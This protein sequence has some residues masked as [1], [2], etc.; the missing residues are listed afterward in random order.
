MSGWERARSEAQK[1]T[2]VDEVLL[3][4]KRL[5]LS[6]PFDTIRLATIA[7]ELSFT[8]AN[9]YKYF[10]SKEEIYLT[11]LSQEIEQFSIDLDAA[12]DPLESSSPCDSN[13]APDAE[14]QP[15]EAPR[16]T[17]R[18]RKF[19]DVW[20]QLM[21]ERRA[22]LMLLACAGHILEKNVSDVTLL[23]SK[24][25]MLSAMT[26]WTVPALQRFFP[27]WDQARALS[28]L[29]LLVILANG[30]HSFCGLSPEQNELLA[31]HGLEAMAS[32]E[33]QSTYRD[34]LIRIRFGYEG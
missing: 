34:L 30:L 23:R 12:L 2:R 5:L 10:R 14:F 31:Q 9:L 21:A 19:I 4:A 17:R 32:Q 16:Q 11:L 3:V 8:R 13:H 7:K 25:Q 6:E 28:E 24:Q 33:F 18:A 27:Q 29:N 26:T 15:D 1:A 22:M 20:A